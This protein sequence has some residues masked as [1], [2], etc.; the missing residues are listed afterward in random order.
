MGYLIR[1]SRNG[2]S[3]FTVRI[4]KRDGTPHPGFPGSVTAN[5]TELRPAFEKHVAAH[6]PAFKH[7][8]LP[9]QSLK[10]TEK[11]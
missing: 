3:T 1:V 6:A 7:K 11:I 8:V 4:T 2:D 5:K 9:G 10:A